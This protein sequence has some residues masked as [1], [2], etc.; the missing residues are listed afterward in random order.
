MVPRTGDGEMLYRK[1]QKSCD[2][3]KKIRIIFMGN[4]VCV[5][6]SL[7]LSF[8]NSLSCSFSSPDDKLSENIWFCI[9]TSYS[10][11]K[12]GCHACPVDT[13]DDR[14]RTEK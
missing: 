8:C 10:A 14:Q 11:E 4:F 2:K 9:S 13:T 5:T 12:V 1:K 3:K 6:L 7:Y